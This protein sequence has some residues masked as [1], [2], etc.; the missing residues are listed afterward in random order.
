[1]VAAVSAAFPN[2]SVGTLPL[3]QNACP[4]LT[5][6]AMD[7]GMAASFPPE[8]NSIRLNRC[9]FSDALPPHQLR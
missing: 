8:E 9:W 2:S 6:L 1:M 5:A 7:L 3:K 4:T